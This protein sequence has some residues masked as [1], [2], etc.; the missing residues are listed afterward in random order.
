MK[1]EYKNITGTS[2]KGLYFC[3]ECCFGCLQW[4]C[5]PYTLHHC[6]IKHSF[7]ESDTQIFKL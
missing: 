7:K 2:V 5:V 6:V 4:D 1:I 3:D